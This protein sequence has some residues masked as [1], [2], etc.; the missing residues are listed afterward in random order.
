MDK[1]SNLAELIRFLVCGVAAALTDYLFCQVTILILNRVSP[2]MTWIWMTVISTGVG[3]I[4]GVIVNYLISTFWVY[5]NVD[6]SVKT[7]SVRFIVWFTVLSFMAMVLS[8]LTML[9]CNL[10]VMNGLHQESIM[11]VSLLTL[12]KDHGIA[13][14]AQAI[15]WTY[16]ISFCLKTIVRLVFNYFTRKFILYKAPKEP[17]EPVEE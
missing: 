8:I 3:F 1:N 13:F 12:I 16:F 2:D 15:F 4:F 7:K 5:Q 10:V 11:D 9:L 14:L 6:K 17:Q